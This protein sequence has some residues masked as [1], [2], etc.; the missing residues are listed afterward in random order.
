MDGGLPRVE[1]ETHQVRIAPAIRIFGLNQPLHAP[2]WC[3]LEKPRNRPR[4]EKLK[5]VNHAS[6]RER[7]TLEQA[8]ELG[9]VQLRRSGSAAEPLPPATLD[10][11]AQTLQRLDV[12]GDAKAG[13]M[14]AKLAVQHRPLFRHR[15]VAVAAPPPGNPPP[16]ARSLGL[17][18][19]LHHPRPPLS[20]AVVLLQLQPPAHPTLP[21]LSHQSAQTGK[22]AAYSPEIKRKITGEIIWDTTPGLGHNRAN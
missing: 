11:K 10:L 22:T 7:V 20:A 9:P 4:L 2:F 1:F 19:V 18:P 12:P 3:R 8:V 15:K 14:A 21:A 5:T 13:I 16:T 17:N 6:G